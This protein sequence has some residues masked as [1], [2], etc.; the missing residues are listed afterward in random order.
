MALLKRPKPAFGWPIALVCGASSLTLHCADESALGSP[1]ATP[2][3]AEP[4]DASAAADA[5]P[6]LP[7]TP[8]R[9]EVTP[10]QD[11]YVNLSTLSVVEPQASE[12]TLWDLR[13]SGF[14]IL[15][16]SGPSGPGNGAAFGPSDDLDLLFDTVPDVPFRGDKARGAISDWYLYSEGVLYSRAH[17]YALRAGQQ[18]WKLQLLSYYAELDGASTSAVYRLRYAEVTPQGVAPT[19]DIPALNATT[20]SQVLSAASKAGCLNFQTGAELQLDDAERLSRN[21]WHLCLRRNDAFVNSGYS[22]PASV[23]A[24]DLNLELRES[25][26]SLQALTDASLLERFDAVDYAALAAPGVQYVQ[27]D[28]IVSLLGDNWVTEASALAQPIAD[29]AWLVRGA[30]GQRHYGLL[31]TALDG[32]SATA[33]GS[34][35]LQVKAFDPVTEASTQ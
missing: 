24:A 33:P 16:N 14:Q 18:L 32:A 34:V 11:T 21:D 12:P 28:S 20:G 8:W 1:R 35:R 2:R 6:A 19:V 5:E 30:D 22:G 27:D 4:G 9:V 23:A 3:S 25:A 13:F 26:N 17:V 29:V 31:F 7:G 10:G 15:T